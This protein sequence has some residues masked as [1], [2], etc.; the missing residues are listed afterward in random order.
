MDMH[1]KIPLILCK[2]ETIFPPAFWN[3]MEHLLVLSAKEAYLGAPIHYQW[4]YPFEHFY[5]SLKQKAKNKSQLESSMVMACS[6]YEIKTIGSHYFDPKLLAM[7]LTL[8]R[9][10]VRHDNHAPFTLTIF[11]MKRSP[12]GHGCKRNHTPEE[13]NA[14]HLHILLNYGEVQPHLQ[15]QKE[16]FIIMSSVQPQL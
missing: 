9:N 1:W 13:Y 5:H 8:L 10:K 7:M 15:Y 11:K 14:V 16:L 4:M 2:L 12:F 6:I 3:I